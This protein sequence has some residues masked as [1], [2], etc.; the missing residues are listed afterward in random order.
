MSLSKLMNRFIKLSPLFTVLIFS[1]GSLSCRGF[2]EKGKNI[3][4]A[5]KDSLIN[6]INEVISEHPAEIG[7]AA[8]INN[9]DTILV[10]NREGYPLMSMFKLHQALAVVY[11]QKQLHRDIDSI[12]YIERR[13]LNP[14][15]WSPMLDGYTEDTIRISVARLLEYILIHSDNNAS[16]I[17]FDSI[18]N[19]EGTDR[20]IRSIVPCEGFSIQY[21]EAQMSEDHAKS[22]I[23]Q[24]SP[25][26]YVELVD[27]LFTDSADVTPEIEYIKNLMSKCMTGP[28]RIA[29][30]FQ[31]KP[32]IEFAH[33][34]GSG[35]INRNGEIV[36]VND[37]GY[38]MLPDGKNYSIAV[39]VKNYGGT[40]EEAESAI[41]AISKLIYEY[42]SRQ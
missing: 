25:L 9:R 11:R 17:L 23:N 4:N 16:N 5:T 10:N 14:D 7:V 13:S 2:S 32:G 20:Y 28:G 42:V 34:T 29:S 1:L 41:A 27:K 22:Y 8:I 21:T 6:A 35:Y 33:R 18:I 24:T 36:A 30:A 38:V 12:M 39:F 19:P 37:G 3:D 15:T 40:Q 26:A 31:G